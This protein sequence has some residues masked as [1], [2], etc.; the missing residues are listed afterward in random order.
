M[1]QI[2]KAQEEERH[3]IANEL[4]DE[5]IQALMATSNYAFGVIREA[6]KKKKI[7]IIS[8]INWIANTVL[9]VSRDI[10]NLCLDL[11]PHILDDMGLSAALRWLADKIQNENNL[12]II[13]TISGEE[14]RLNP[15]I[16]TNIFRIIKEALNN[17]IRH[18]QATK[19]GI[20]IEI[21]K[22]YCLIQIID[23]GK[24]FTLPDNMA[25]YSHEGKLGILSMKQRARFINGLLNIKSRINMGT[26]VILEVTL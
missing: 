20:K 4:H 11:R 14:R 21:A 17:I 7:E 6:N 22:N 5:S 9:D 13:L 1:S 2:F 19:A 8:D 26:E 16:E 15:E 3:R 12:E 24:G 18:S 25:L 23:N 10:R